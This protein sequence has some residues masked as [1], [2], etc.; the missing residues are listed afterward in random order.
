MTQS[1]PCNTQHSLHWSLSRSL[2]C[3]AY[4]I[5]ISLL[6]QYESCIHHRS[7]N[8]WHPHT[9]SIQFAVQILDY[10]TNG[11]GSSSGTRDDVAVCST[12][13]FPVFFVWSIHSHLGSSCSVHRGHQTMLNSKCVVQHLRHWSQTVG[14]TRRV[15]N[16]IFLFA[17]FGGIFKSLVEVNQAIL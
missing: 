12:S 10:R 1:Y 4:R 5:I 16:D 15:G 8:H 13:Q 6:L 3:S 9:H 11:Y 17:L 7:A 14:R 2:H